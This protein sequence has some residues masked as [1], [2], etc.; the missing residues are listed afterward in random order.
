MQDSVSRL[1][2]IEGEAD[3]PGWAYSVGVANGYAYLGR[4]YDSTVNS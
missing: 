3:T 1:S 2:R 4:V